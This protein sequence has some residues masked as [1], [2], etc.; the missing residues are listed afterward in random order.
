[1]AANCRGVGAAGQKEQNAARLKMAR[2]C[3]VLSGAA[4]KGG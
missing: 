3:V 1:V 2:D 4:G